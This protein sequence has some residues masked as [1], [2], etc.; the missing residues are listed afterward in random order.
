MQNPPVDV[1][2]V[3]P[4]PRA[5]FSCGDVDQRAFVKQ[6]RV[7]HSR[8]M[9]SQALGDPARRRKS[10]D[11]PLVGRGLAPHKVDE[12][13]VGG[14]GRKV[15]VDPGLAPED[16]PGI[17]AVSFGDEY[18]V[19]GVGRVVQDSAPVRRPNH[20]NGVWQEG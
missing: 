6:G 17:S 2:A 15:I 5:V 11:V 16:L 10:P 18:W 19:S 1:Q 12:A 9:M 3:K 7:A 14:P 4:G 13:T 8:M 20:L